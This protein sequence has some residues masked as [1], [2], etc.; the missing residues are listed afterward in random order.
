[1][2]ACKKRR[3]EL[4]IRCGHQVRWA[5]ALMAATVSPRTGAI[6]GELA[7]ADKKASEK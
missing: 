3:R 1:M 4:A 6:R 2:P 5:F 7:Q